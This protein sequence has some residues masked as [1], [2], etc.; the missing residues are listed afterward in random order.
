MSPG[1]QA[2]PLTKARETEPQ[3][4][5][6]SSEKSGFLKSHFGNPEAG[7]VYGVGNDYETEA[8]MSKDEKASANQAI[9]YTGAFMLCLLVAYLIFGS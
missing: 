4:E 6:G 3:D 9:W 5:A 1:P 7:E 8:Q 2:S